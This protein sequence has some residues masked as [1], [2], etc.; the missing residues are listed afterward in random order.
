MKERLFDLIENLSVKKLDR[1]DL[2]DNLDLI[3]D[4]GFDSM[5]LVELS[6]ELEDELGVCLSED[7]LDIEKLRNMSYLLSLVG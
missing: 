4:L 1:T 2:S 5:T 3:D 7:D 6:V